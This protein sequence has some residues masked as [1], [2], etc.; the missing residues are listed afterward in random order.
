MI[1][2]RYP[3]AEDPKPPILGA[4]NAILQPRAPHATLD[5]LRDTQ[6]AVCPPALVPRVNSF[7]SFYRNLPVGPIW[8]R[9]RLHFSSHGPPSKPGLQTSIK[10]FKKAFI[11]LHKFLYF[12]FFFIGIKYTQYKSYYCNHLEL[13]CWRRLWR[14][15]WT[16]KRT[17]QS[18]LKEINP[19]YSLKGLMQKL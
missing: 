12:L 18:I 15:L 17:N 16:S 3:S 13:W 14:I 10:L 7:F 5:S 8:D 2:L 19:E 1:D 11:C 4:L 9:K 6:V